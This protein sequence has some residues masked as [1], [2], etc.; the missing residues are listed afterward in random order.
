[1]FDFI[2]SIHPSFHES[3]P[4]ICIWGRHFSPPTISLSNLHDIHAHIEELQS[5]PGS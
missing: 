1:M 3:K 5:S 2:G 4:L